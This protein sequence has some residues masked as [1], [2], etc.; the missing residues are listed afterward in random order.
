[1]SDFDYAAHGLRATR[2]PDIPGG[3]PTVGAVLDWGMA[4][5]PDRMALIGRNGRYT[6]RQLASVVNRAARAM[7]AAGIGRFDRV[8][9]S[10]PNDVEIVIAFLATMRI[11]AIWVGLPRILSLPE[12]VFILED[13]GVCLLLAEKALQ[14]QLKTRGTG[15]PALAQIW[16]AEPGDAH[17]EWS[18]RL[19]DAAEDLPPQSP[20][21]P[22]APAVIA[23][24]SGT[25]GFP[26]GVVHSQHNML[27]P[28]AVAVAGGEFS[29]QDNTG[30]LLPLTIPNL[31]I[32]Q[33]LILLQAGGTTIVIDRTRP[34]ELADWIPANG[35]STSSRCRPCITTCC[36]SLASWMASKALPARNAVVPTCRRNRVGCFAS[37]LV[38][39]CR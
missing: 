38:A 1:M 21:D 24:T 27:V 18:A 4:T 39:T 9:A 7:L 25:T 31:L 34:Q 2:R 26:K 23:Y 32:V 35:S 30:V 10:L 22:F 15:V 5:H 16:D 33:P 3:R 17:S 29:P 11:G 37:A 8:A 36:L 19:R 14:A 13:A 6:Y 12:K 28:G 20:L